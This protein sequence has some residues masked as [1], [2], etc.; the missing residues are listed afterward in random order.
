VYT[1]QT[2]SPTVDRTEASYRASG[3]SWT[4]RYNVYLYP[5]ETL[6]NL[7]G[8]VNIDNN[9]GKNFTNTNLSLVTGDVKVVQDQ[10]IGTFQRANYGYAP[11]AAAQMALVDNFVPQPVSDYY[12]Y[13]L[14]RKVNVTTGSNKQ[15]ELFNRVNKVP[16]L[17]QYVASV[18]SGANPQQIKF[19]V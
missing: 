16:V 8:Y 1:V 14:S 19:S 5:S 13:S 12:M 4:A 7:T 15:I 17:K 3:L 6:A 18:E 10:L 11:G 9:S 2:N